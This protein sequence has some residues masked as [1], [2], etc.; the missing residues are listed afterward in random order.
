M[1]TEKVPASACG[2]PDRQ[3]LSRYVT[4]RTRQGHK[5]IPFEKDSVV[6]TE[7]TALNLGVEPGDSIWVENPDGERVEMTLTGV[8]ENYMFTRLYVSNAQ[9]QTLLGTQDIPG[10][11]CTPRPAATVPPTA[12]P[13]GRPCW[14]ATM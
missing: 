8:T 14:P 3:Q 10:T 7:K 5:A 12:T 4:F 1:P 6:L 11:R 13:C 2:C 9:L